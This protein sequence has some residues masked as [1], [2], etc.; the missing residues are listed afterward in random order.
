MAE[1]REIELSSGKVRFQEEGEGRPVV[2]VHGLL[3]NGSLWRKVIPLLDGKQLRSVVPDWPLGAHT[4]PVRSAADL[5]PRGMARL[6]AEFLE[7]LDLNDVTLV[8]NDTGGAIAQ[9]LVVERPERIARLVLTP[10]D[11]FA[12]FLPPAFRPLQHLAKAPALLTAALQPL[13]IRALRRLP[14]AFGWL[15]KRPVPDEVSDTW[16]RP[17]LTDAAIRRDTARFLRAID[18]RDTLAAAERL[19]TFE[20]PV[21]LAWAKEDRFFPLEQAHRLAELFP[22][23]QVEE[24]PDSYTFVP[25]DQPERL[26]ALI[27]EFA[28]REQRFTSLSWDDGSEQFLPSDSALSTDLPSR[29]SRANKRPGVS[30]R[31]EGHEDNSTQT[32]H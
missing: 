18:S 28:G 17:F 16:L 20:R 3:V 26:A 4:T 22:D 1:Y 19:H 14:I 8:A 23:A 21:L 30:L 11:A 24:I 6:I 29:Q 32:Q 12:N 5:S 7:A 13:R 25:E 31:T 27:A 9:L 15:S 2:F 10:C